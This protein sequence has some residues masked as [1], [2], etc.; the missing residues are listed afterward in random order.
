[1]DRKLGC[2]WF[3]VIFHIL[4]ARELGCMELWLFKMGDSSASK[5]GLFFLLFPWDKLFTVKIA[6]FLF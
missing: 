4:Y 6:A 5:W 2:L 3:A 1:M